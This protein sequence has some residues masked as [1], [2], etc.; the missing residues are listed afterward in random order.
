MES[1]VARTDAAKIIS[2]PLGRVRKPW[3]PIRRQVVQL[4]RWLETAVVDVHGGIDLRLAKLVRTACTAFE[5]AQRIRRTLSY[6]GELGTEA[7]LD[8]QTWLAYDSALQAR[9]AGCDKALTA[10][11]LARDAKQDAWAFLDGNAQNAPQAAQTSKGDGPIAALET[12][13]DA[14]QGPQKANKPDSSELESLGSRSM[15]GGSA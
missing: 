8:H 2:L 3:V 11:G 12:R 14:S 6:S 15:A 9:E 7:G 5:S 10:L 4:R 13:Q 1:A